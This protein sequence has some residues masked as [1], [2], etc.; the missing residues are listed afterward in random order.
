MYFK[1]IGYGLFTAMGGDDNI[2]FELDLVFRTL[3]K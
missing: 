1:Q 2:A 3:F